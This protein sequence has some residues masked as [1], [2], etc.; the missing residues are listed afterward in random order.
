VTALLLTSAVGFL[1]VALLSP[2]APA[3]EAAA[4]APRPE[5]PRADDN[6]TTKLD[7]MMEKT[8]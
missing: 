1:L 2:A 4:P 7:D 6:D 3:D 5:A 8:P